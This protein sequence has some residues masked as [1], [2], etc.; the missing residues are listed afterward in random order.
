[1]AENMDVEG[2]ADPV[3]PAPKTILD[4]LMKVAFVFFLFQL[5]SKKLQTKQRVEVITPDLAVQRS[6]ESRIE[7][8]LKQPNQFGSLIG[9][10][11]DIDLP[12]FPTHND[13]GIPLGTVQ[14]CLIV[15]FVQKLTS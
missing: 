9:M 2:A 1:M 4:Q 10:H 7:K 5:F 12:T 15:F 6:A 3:E 11:S 8:A 13:D 14:Y